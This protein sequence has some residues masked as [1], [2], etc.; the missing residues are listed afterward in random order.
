[1]IFKEITFYSSD[2]KGQKKFYSCTLG[3]KIISEADN[4]FTVQAGNTLLSFVFR[5]DATNYHFAFN[6]PCNQAVQA[7]SWLK[8]RV[9]VLDHKGYEI[10]PF[11]DWN[12]E[13]VYFYDNDKNIVEFIARKN[14]NNQANTLFSAQN[15]SEVS[16]IGLPVDNVESV[17]D[18]IRKKFPVQIYSGNL[19]QFCAAGDERGL[20]II[21][22][23]N[24][25]KWIPR[26]DD[27]FRSPFIVNLEFSGSAF[28]LI[29][30]NDVL[31]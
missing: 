7:L 11:V 9:T 18:S 30:E 4:F 5:E 24:S 17:F 1:M 16:E 10:V 6:I 21:I 23:N 26:D 8:Q 12:A 20:F 14:L 2:I 28:Q 13:A 3:F 19:S 29:Y 31:S 15:V 27:A 22:D 25:K